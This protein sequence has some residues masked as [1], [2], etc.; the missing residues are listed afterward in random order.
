MFSGAKGVLAELLAGANGHLP[1][2]PEE[3][4]NFFYPD[5]AVARMRTLMGFSIGRFCMPR[6]TSY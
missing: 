1:I 5:W 4:D 3:L 6:T 2:L